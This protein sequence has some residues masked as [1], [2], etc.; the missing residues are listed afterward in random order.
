MHPRNSDKWCIMDVLFKNSLILAY[1]SFHPEV[2]WVFKFPGRRTFLS[3]WMTE[4][5]LVALWPG[6]LVWKV[7]ALIGMTYMFFVSYRRLSWLCCEHLKIMC[8]LWSECR[9]QCM[10]VRTTPLLLCLRSFMYLL[11]LC[12]VPCP[13]LRM[14]SPSVLSVCSYVSFCRL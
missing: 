13:G 9:I 6:R 11:I 2:G 14:V 5:E 1:S 3:F 7:S 8:L 12:P 4:F 10:L